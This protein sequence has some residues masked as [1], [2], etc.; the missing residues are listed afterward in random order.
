[1]SGGHNGVIIT[2]NAQPAK[3]SGAPNASTDTSSC[4]Y[5][6]L[7]TGDLYTYDGATWISQSSS[8]NGYNQSFVIANW[9]TQEITITEATHGQGVNPI[10]QVF[11]ASGNERGLEEINRNATGDVVLTVLAGAE[12]DGD[13]SI[14]KTV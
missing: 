6:D 12:F 4:F 11:D 3:G 9:T 1:M 10:V 2:G 8:T 14:I 5:I 7:D 13:V